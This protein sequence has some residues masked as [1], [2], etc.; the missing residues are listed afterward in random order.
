MAAALSKEKEKN[1][2][3]KKKLAQSNKANEDLC[4][5]LSSAKEKND[6]TNKML[7]DLIKVS[8]KQEKPQITETCDDT[9]AYDKSDIG[10]RVRWGGTTEEHHSDEATITNFYHTS[11]GEQHELTYDDGRKFTYSMKQYELFKLLP[12]KKKRKAETCNDTKTST[13]DYKVDGING[14]YVGGFVIMPEELGRP[15]VGKFPHGIGVWT[16]DGVGRDNQLLKHDGN[17]KN[18]KM[19]G[20]GTETRWKWG[21]AQAAGQKYSIKGEWCDGVKK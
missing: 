11:L 12:D 3:L 2:S 9:L 21:S 1:A 17:W 7:S 19:H 6:E 15:G 18:G 13:F 4:A 5:G 20:E 8:D 16:L 10:R 14:S